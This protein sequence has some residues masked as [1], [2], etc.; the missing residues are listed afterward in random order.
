MWSCYSL[1]KLFVKKPSK[2]GHLQRDLLQ[3]GTLHRVSSISKKSLL[4]RNYPKKALSHH[5]KLTLFI[6]LRQKGPFC[7]APTNGPSVCASH[8]R[9]CTRGALIC[10]GMYKQGPFQNVL[11]LRALCKGPWALFIRL[12]QR[13]P[14][15][16]PP[17]TSPRYVLPIKSPPQRG[18][19]FVQ[20]C[21]NKGPSKDVLQIRFHCKCSPRDT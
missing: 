12:P 13:G 19:F 6:K 9:P 3:E 8:K 10:T 7:R 20:E 21:T 16:K 2:Q 5:L 15:Y 11:P 17:Q 18:P 14:L 1:K 4:Q